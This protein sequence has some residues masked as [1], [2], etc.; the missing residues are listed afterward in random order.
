MVPSLRFAGSL[1]DAEVLADVGLLRLSY[2][3]QGN[4]LFYVTPSGI[5][6]YENR[7]RESP[8]VVTVEHEIRAFLTSPLFIERHRSACAKWEQAI[9]L[10][11]GADSGQ[12]LTTIGHLC[13]EALQEFVANLANENDVDVSAIQPAKTVARLKAV[14]ASRAG[15]IGNTESAFIDALV[16]YWG[17]VADLAQRQE[18][19][20]QREGSAL[21]W[22]DARRLV[23]QTMV[24]MYEV[25]RTLE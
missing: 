17:A 21:V 18:H 1:G 14:L 7:R 10:L 8:P 13:R 20:S 15:S 12:Q 5:R 19:G 9:G 6:Y 22:E 23:F 16:S 11:W 3:S 25:A 24:L 4:R 2:N